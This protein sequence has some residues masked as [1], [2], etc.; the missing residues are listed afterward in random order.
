[1]TR[2]HFGKPCSCCKPRQQ[3]RDVSCASLCRVFRQ[4][5]EAQ[6]APLAA[7]ARAVSTVDVRRPSLGVAMRP[8][9][10]RP[11]S[12][13]YSSGAPCARSVDRYVSSVRLYRAASGHDLIDLRMKNAP[14]VRM[15]LPTTGRF[16]LSPAAKFDMVRSSDLTRVA[17]K[18]TPPRR[19][20][21]ELPLSA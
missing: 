6:A 12:M 2:V 14:Q 20:L 16:K 1:M 7:S 4:G 10:A 3:V 21:H 18:M 11:P 13:K 8:S 5:Q 19:T 17:V 9:R 15:M